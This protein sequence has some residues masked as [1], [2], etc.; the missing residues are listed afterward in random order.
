VA[1]PGAH[2]RQGVATSLGMAGRYL[3]ETREMAI[4]VVG[5]PQ[6]TGRCEVCVPHS[7]PAPTPTPA[8]PRC[9]APTPTLPPST[10][11][12][13]PLLARL[14]S[15]GSCS[16]YIYCLLPAGTKSAPLRLPRPSAR[17]GR[18][19]GPARAR[20]CAVPLVPKRNEND[21]NDTHEEATAPYCQ[22]QSPLQRPGVQW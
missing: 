17:R 14:G 19:R 9:P 7:A 4:A 6:A 8:A 21:E 2:Q 1:W 15:T 5:V 3:I 13:E 11:V 12:L 10:Q 18:G 22:H 16:Y 20:R